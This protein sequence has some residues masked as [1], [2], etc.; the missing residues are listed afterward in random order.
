[1][2]VLH[3]NSD[4]NTARS[5]CDKT[6]SNCNRSLM[7]KAKLSYHDG[8]VVMGKVLGGGGETY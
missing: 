4:S 7:C 5:C 3:Q 6:H 1:M 8:G 2:C